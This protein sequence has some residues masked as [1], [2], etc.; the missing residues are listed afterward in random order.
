M[1]EKDNTTGETKDSM[2]NP[3]PSDVN[4][5]MPAAVTPPVTTESPVEKSKVKVFENGPVRVLGPCE[6]TLS[7]GTV[8]EKTNGI[9]FCRCGASAN[10]PFCD[11]SHKSNGYKG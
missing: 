4:T 11:A 6:I 8:V 2:V 1:L 10:M 3:N 9:S 7:D 5:G